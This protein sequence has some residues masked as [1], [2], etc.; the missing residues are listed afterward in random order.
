VPIGALMME[1]YING[2]LSPA[3]ER[4]ATAFQ[5]RHISYASLI[6]KELKKM[7]KELPVV[8]KKDS[9]KTKDPKELKKL[10]EEAKKKAEAAKKAAEEAKKKA[11]EEA[12]KKAEEEAK[13]KAEAAKKAAEEKKRSAVQNAPTTTPVPVSNDSS[14]VVDSLNAVE[15]QSQKMRE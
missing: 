14:V 6:K 5:H 2:K 4:K 11:A 8:E 9:A 15:P 7:G 13:K 3:S 12:K 1:Q 10:E